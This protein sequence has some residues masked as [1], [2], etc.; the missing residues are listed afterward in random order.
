MDN[1]TIQYELINSLKEHSNKVAIE[2]KGKHITYKELDDKS[3]I[4][5]SFI[6]NQKINK[7]SFIGVMIQDKVDMI[8]TILGIIKARCVFVPLDSSYPSERSDSMLKTS[9]LESVFVC[10]GNMNRINV[11]N[12][13]NIC[14]VLNGDD[15]F[16]YTQFFY[17]P[18]DK[19]YIYFTSGTTGEPKCILGKNISLLHFIK[20]EIREFELTKDFVFSQLTSQCHDPFMRD[21][22]VPLCIG[23]KIC[24]PKDR[25]LILDSDSLTNWINDKQISLIHCTPS[26]FKIFNHDDIKETDYESLKYI[27]LAGER[28]QSCD[29]DKWYGVFDNRINLINL[30]GPTETTL[31]KLFYRI[32]KEDSKRENIPIGKPISGAKAIILDKNMKICTEGKTGQIYIRTPYRSF[33]YFK[34]EEKTK[35]RFI[36]NPFNNNDEDLIYKTGDLG[37]LDANGDI[38][39][40]GRVDRQIKIRGFRVELRG[41][42]NTLMNHEHIQNAVVVYKSVHSIE[43]YICVYI[44]KYKDSKATVQNVKDYLKTKLPSY[45]IPSYIMFLDKIPINNNG[46]VDYRN[47]PDFIAEDKRY[48]RAQTPLERKLQEIFEHVLEV[49]Q[50]SVDMGFLDIGG[51]SL[52]AMKVISKIYSELGVNISLKEIFDNPTIQELSRIIV[53]YKSEEVNAIKTAEKREYYPTSSAQ[54]RMFVLNKIGNNSINYNMPMVFEIDGELDKDKCQIAINQIIKRHEILKTSFGLVDGE[55]VQ[56][57]ND[58]IKLAVDYKEIEE[59]KVNE[60]IKGFI[61]PFDLNIAPLLRVNILKVKSDRYYLLTDMHHIIMDGISRRILVSQFCEFYQ[62]LYNDEIPKL[63]YKD[64]AIWQNEYIKTNEYKKQEH[65]WIEKF[66]GEIPVLNIATDFK[67]PTKLNGKGD[68]ISFEINKDITASLNILARRNKSTLYMVLLSVFNV[69][70]YKY[71]NN[72]DVIIGT[73]ISGRGKDNLDNMLGMFVNTLAMR[74]FPSGDKTFVDFLLEVRKNALS[75]F[76]NQDFQFDELIEK[77]KLKRDLSRN[78]LFDVMFVLQ[79]MKQRDFQLENVDIRPYKTSNKS[80]KFDILLNAVEDDNRI[81][82]MLEFRTDIFK[83]DTMYRLIVHFKNLIRDVVHNPNKKL[84]DIKLINQQEFEIIHGF[85]TRS[86]VSLKCIHEIFESQVESKEKEVAVVDNNSQITYGKLNSKANSL[87]RLLISKGVRKNTVVAMLIDKSIDAVIGILGILKAGAGVMIIDKELPEKRVAHML[88]DSKAVILLTK[89]KRD[90]RDIRTLALNDVDFKKYDSSNIRMEYNAL[91]LLYMV[92]TSGTT[93]LPKGVMVNHRTIVNLLHHQNTNTNIDFKN[94]RV[95]QFASLSFDVCY[96]EYFSTLLNGGKLYVVDKHTKNDINKF[97]EYLGKNKIQI[98]M[99]PT[100]YFRLLSNYDMYIYKIPESLEHIIVAGERLVITEKIISFLRDKGIYLHNHYGPS[101]TH[102]VTTYTIDYEKPLE[103]LPP[104]G[105]PV[106]NTN[107]L[108]LNENDSIQPIGVAGE[109]CVAG[110]FLSRGYTNNKEL[111]KQKFVI[112]PYD[113]NQMMYK[114]GDLARWLCDGNIEY[115][116][117]IDKQVKIR[118]YRIELGEIENILEKHSKIDQAVVVAKEDDDMNKFLCAYIIKKSN[119]SNKEIKSYLNQ[120]LPEYMIPEYVIDIESIPTNKNGKIEKSKLPEPLKKVNDNGFIIAETDME[121]QLEKLW[122]EVLKTDSKISI[123]DDFFKL[124]GHSLRAIALSAQIYEILNIEIPLTQIFK[125]PSLKEMAEYLEG[126]TQDIYRQLIS[127]PKKEYYKLSSAQHRMYVLN[128]LHKDSTAY[129][130]PF[131]I[132][133]KGE[134]DINKLENVFKELIKRHESF[135]TSFFIKETQPIQKIYKSVNFRIEYNEYDKE[136]EVMDSFIE[137]FD[138]KKAPLLRVKTVKLQDSYLLLIDMHHIIADGVSLKILVEEFTRLYNGDDLPKLEY[139]YRDY[140]HW[141]NK[142]FDLNM[143]KA[144]KE[145]WNE[146][147]TKEIPKLNLHR[148]YNRKIAT[149]KIGDNYKFSISGELKNKLTELANQNNCTLYMVLLSAYSILL[150]K[151]SNQNDII[152]GSPISGRHNVKVQNII[153]MFVNTL[154]LRNYPDGKKTYRRYLSEVRESTLKAYE[155]Q[156]YQLEE[157][158]D[159]LNLKRSYHESILFD[160]MFTLQNIDFEDIKLNGLEVEIQEYDNKTAK[161]D[162]CLDA[163][164]AKG[165]YFIIQ[166]DSGLFKR[167]TIIN[168]SNHL[169]NII[170]NIC[171]NQDIRIEDIDVL[172]EQDKSRILGFNRKETKDGS[173]LIHQAFQRQV[174]SYPNNIALVYED[175][176]LTYLQLN[177]KANILARE[178][179]KQHQIGDVVGIITEKSINMIVSVLSVL[180]AGLTYV[181]IDIDYPIKRIKHILDEININTVLISNKAKKRIKLDCK[182]VNI[183]EFEYRGKDKD[184]DKLVPDDTP[185]YII[186][187]SGTTGKPKGIVTEHKSVMN[188]VNVFNRK[189]SLCDKDTT[190]QQ[191]SF[192][193]DGFVEEVFSMLSIGG[194]IVLPRNEYVK[195][196]KKLRELIVNNEVSILSCSPL[197]LS[198][199]NELED[200]TCVHT[201]LSSSDVLKREYILNIIKYSKVYNMYGPTEAT[202]CTTCYE[203]TDEEQENIPIGAPLANYQVYILDSNLRQVPIGVAGEIFISGVGVARGY[204]NN[205]ELTKEKFINNPFDNRYKMYKTG[206]IG[207]WRSNG[208]IEYIGRKDSQVKIRGYRVEIN[209]IENQILGSKLVK[210]VFVQAKKDEDQNYL[211]AYVTTDQEITV[212]QI[213]E[214]L[215]D[216]LP[217]YMIPSYYMTNDK[218]PLTLNG[219]IDKKALQEFVSLPMGVEF[220]KP[221][222]EVEKRVAEL[223][224]RVLKIKEDISINDSFFDLGGNSLKLVELAACVNNELGIQIPLATIIENLKVK[225]LAQYLISD[226]KKNSQGEFVIFNENSKNTIFYF[227]PVTGFGLIFNDFAKEMIYNK[228]VAFNFIET[229]DRVKKYINIIK[230][231]KLEGSYTLVGYCM[232][233]RLAFEVAKELEKQ[234]EIVKELIILDSYRQLEK[235]LYLK[236]DVSEYSAEL[237]ISIEKDRRYEFFKDDIIAKA[238]AYYQHSIELIDGGVID[239][240]I[241]LVTSEE[242]TKEEIDMKGWRDATRGNYVVYEGKGSHNEM[243]NKLNANLITDIIN[244]K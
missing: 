199:L 196:V 150:H 129:N 225:E 146:V 148:D 222:N 224:Q 161:F 145:Y 216:R 133:I 220:E 71:T 82:C 86:E 184:L 135:R 162:I 56:I 66:N 169:V 132:K 55:P 108:I 92:Y 177:R 158:V 36:V 31:A 164:E 19:I 95:A 26:L 204:I 35:E 88:K 27:L 28:V 209:E 41:I 244:R 160:T 91:D 128:Q 187:T 32:K 153:G 134:L 125:A 179:L 51:H 33:G 165:I 65:Y 173:T 37:R 223:F 94:N 18:E 174:K 22:F 192:T 113:K 42:E 21:V 68:T 231:T 207:L 213:R 229:K 141:Q 130:M 3:N 147:Y 23:A 127:T 228:L 149:E 24:I 188:Y 235:P 54:K 78:P 159:K 157:L 117:R 202:V 16:D 243:I 239:A 170:D 183:D 238:R 126:A 218:M 124:G 227:P 194:K 87:A 123:N 5:A 112:N 234:G 61:E 30:Y 44:V 70:L 13:F 58:N 171:T 186:Y 206:D 168:M 47:L 6:K 118:G 72:Q 136:Q 214:Y 111:M 48:M 59:S 43:K 195:D 73:P 197:I 97:M 103:V 69:L 90:V 39:F 45:M 230:Q 232:G 11:K 79:N 15:V 200:M 205:N 84:K 64:Y 9:Q 62:S 217:E 96:Q 57:I 210:E 221:S 49:K 107:I 131:A 176:Y 241:Y 114:T 140:S 219:K 100:A 236:Y 1:K 102:V 12:T 4:V 38:L 14:S 175:E 81:Q 52:N 63:Q 121:K 53:S 151:Y 193:F 172:S 142:V 7:G 191:A 139:Q 178:L 154:A 8:T 25:S 212:K 144:Q 76:E 109:L 75:D 180:K 155:N 181:P 83:R 201:F 85:N 137:P 115:L 198:Q 152:I 93:G 120:R 211:C 215:K 106:V 190:L 29:I 77:L 105:R 20:W 104:I 233:G 138:L 50:I 182:I 110:D 166:Y 226:F 237:A 89:E 60:L 80:S 46:K 203:C 185:A 10:E 116:G 240:D 2:Y 143:L 163:V 208:M 40:E 101:E 167:D 156:D 189:F 99:L 98:A 119:I 242:A 67:R 122:Q 34:D 17:K 74:N